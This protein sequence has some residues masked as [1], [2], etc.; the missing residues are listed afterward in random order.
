MKRLMRL[1]AR[2]YPKAWRERYGVEFASLLEDLKP[3]LGM[4]LDIVKGALLMQMTS[5]TWSR[6]LAVSGMLGALAAFGTSFAMPRKYVSQAVVKITPTPSPSQ[7]A[8][9]VDQEVTGHINSMSQVILRRA[10]LVTIINEHSLYK[11]ERSRI[12]MEVVLELMRKNI[13]C[14]GL[15]GSSSSPSPAPDYASKSRAT[16]VLRFGARM[17]KKSSITIRARARSSPY[18]WRWRAAS[19]VSALP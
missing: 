11:M 16:A 2:L 18:A 7:P 8:A 17:A 4:S 14:T 6:I 1:A 5:G 12:P 3:D 15:R 10:G 13:R 9:A 19:C